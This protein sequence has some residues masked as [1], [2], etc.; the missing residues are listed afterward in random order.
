MAGI[1]A[2]PNNDTARAARSP[3]AG[4]RVLF[5]TNLWPDEERPW[6]GT[7]VRTQ[8]DSLRALGVELEVMTIRGYAGRGA[9]A[10]AA[11][12]A[13]A[14]NRRRRFD[15][16]HAHYGHAGVV[17]R[18]QLRAPLVVSY[19]GSDLIGAFDAAGRVTSRSRA[20]VAVFRQLAAVSD[21]TITKTDEMAALLPAQLRARN[22]VIPNGVDLEDFTPQD[23]AAARRQ[24]GWDPNAPVALFVG[25]PALPVKG[26]ALARLAV[27]A[28]TTALPGLMLRAATGVAPGD[29]PTWMSA[30]DVLV[31]TSIAE[32]SPNAVKEALAVE[33]PVVAT[34]VGDV[35]ERLAGLPACHAGAPDPR[36]LGAAL[37]AAVRHGRVPEAREAMG[38]LGLARV[39]QR[40]ADVYRTVT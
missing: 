29:M 20:E 21:A 24:L 12:R 9:Y 26:F 18:L 5:V 16:V 17:G 27:A 23:Q 8:A 15:V 25:D 13:A 6:H 11:V 22:H 1:V 14:L 2:L 39:A 4:M 28:A 7:F 37:V 30:A 3:V 34:A 33:L 32:G 31:F 19:C 40:V 10:R 36:E 38:E 35:P